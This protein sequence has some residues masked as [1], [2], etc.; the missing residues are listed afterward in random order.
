MSPPLRESEWNFSGVRDEEVSACHHWEFS[1]TAVLEID[2]PY[3]HQENN[4]FAKYGS[5]PSA[6][7]KSPFLEYPQDCREDLAK[8]YPAYQ[9]RCPYE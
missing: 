5:F 2:P 8:R 1:R 7:P 3:V 9:L 4:S 6:W